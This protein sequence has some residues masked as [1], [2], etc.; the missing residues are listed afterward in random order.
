MTHKLGPA[1]LVLG[2][3]LILTADIFFMNHLPGA[4][5]VYWTGFTCSMV[6]GVIVLYQ[7][8]RR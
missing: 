6:G 7:I 8:V 1:L 2:Y 4:R 3:L 5:T